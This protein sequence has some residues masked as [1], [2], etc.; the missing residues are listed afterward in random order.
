MGNA[1][2]A[3]WA[4]IHLPFHIALVLLAEGGN[5][6]VVWWRSLEAFHMAG[7]KLDSV[8]VDAIN[9]GKTAQ[10]V[11]ALKEAAK[12]ILKDYGASIEDEDGDTK[13]LNKAL[14]TIS[15]IPDQFWNQTNP[16]SSDP[17]YKSWVESYLTISST[18]LNTVSDAFGISVEM[19]EKPNS[20]D[21]NM[22]TMELEAVNMTITRLRLIVSSPFSFSP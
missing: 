5:Q 11:D 8:A 4:L 7:D 9:T 16:P 15:K 3:Y 21:E 2:Q 1:T 18:V 20:G 19:D 17:N 10:V 22:G 12:K 6:W 13:Y 14:D